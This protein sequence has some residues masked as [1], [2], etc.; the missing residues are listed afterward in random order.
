MRLQIKEL[1]GPDE[2]R[3]NDSNTNNSLGIS[4]QN[5]ANAF[6]CT[7]NRDITNEDNFPLIISVKIYNHRGVLQNTLNLNVNRNNIVN[8]RS[9]Y[10][11]LTPSRNLGGTHFYAQAL[12]NNT[13][14]TAE[15]TISYDHYNYH[16]T[17]KKV[18]IYTR[19]RFT[20]V[21]WSSNEVI[22]DPAQ[23]ESR[24]NS[25]SQN[26]DAFLH[27][28]AQGMYRETIA[29]IIS[30]GNIILYQS[31]ITL[32]QNRKVVA[33]NITDMIAR[34][35]SQA[36]K[37]TGAVDISLLATVSARDSNPPTNNPPTNNV[38]EANL[39]NLVIGNIARSLLNSFLLVTQRSN[40]LAVTFTDNESPTRRSS[41]GTVYVNL[42]TEA[43]EPVT[44]T[45]YTDFPLGYVGH[46]LSTATIHQGIATSWSVSGVARYP[47]NFYELWLSDMV[48]CGLVSIQDARVLTLNTDG[49]TL[50]TAEQMVEVFNKYTAFNGSSMIHRVSSGTSIDTEQVKKVLQQVMARRNIQSTFHVCRDAWQTQGGG[51]GVEPEVRYA[52]NG[53]ECPPGGYTINFVNGTFQVYFA[54]TNAEQS[55]AVNIQTF[56]RSGLAIH[57]GDSYTATGCTTLYCTYSGTTGSTTQLD[58]LEY[59]FLTR[60]L[61]DCSGSNRK[62]LILAYIEERNALQTQNYSSRWYDI[63]APGKCLSRI[64]GPE[65]IAIGQRANYSLIINKQSL[66]AG[67]N[68]TSE[69]RESIRW[70]YR[71]GNEPYQDLAANGRTGFTLLIEEGWVGRRITIR[72]KI[73]LSIEREEIHLDNLSKITR[74]T[75]RSQ[76]VRPQ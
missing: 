26:E 14:F 48:E 13:L 1:T 9:F 71:L 68:I 33:I 36:N 21:Y 59:L 17:I 44:P 56:N 7:L 58:F 47:F 62:R 20:H 70:E 43:L 66:A 31:R 52:G 61:A 35:R 38:E 63:I 74:V 65:T 2:I 19:Q 4:N 23:E 11:T 64:D 34:Y 28:K 41:T 15:N 55:R 53:A 50:R 29:L 72:A 16:A 5:T 25:I 73:I 76:E 6:C 60:S 57:R 42:N 39:L 46:L 8:N 75:R 51:T 30:A 10:F 3:L 69:E 27:I 45:R 37:P 40:L 18:F 22:T 24:R 49:Q 67:D 32:S 54:N 12:I